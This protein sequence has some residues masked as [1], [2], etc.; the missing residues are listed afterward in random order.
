MVR[1]ELSK[2]VIV[3]MLRPNLLTL[4]HNKMAHDVFYIATSPDP[5]YRSNLWPGA[6][7]SGESF[8]IGL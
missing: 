3:Y 7:I 6:T 4:H 2:Y 5:E 1:S 8:N